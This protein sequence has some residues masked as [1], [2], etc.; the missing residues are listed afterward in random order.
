MPPRISGGSLAAVSATLIA[1]GLACSALFVWF[2]AEELALLFLIG[3]TLLVIG[4]AIAVARV[5]DAAWEV[6]G[7]WQWVAPDEWRLLQPEHDPPPTP[8]MERSARALDAARK[9]HLEVGVLHLLLGYVMSVLLAAN[10]LVPMA[11]EESVP[12]AVVVGLLL[13][14]WGEGGAIVVGSWLLHLAA[15]GVRQ[16]TGRGWVLLGLLYSVLGPLAH[17]LVS[18][19]S[20]IHLF[21]WGYG[22]WLSL[23]AVRPTWSVLSEAAMQL[24]DDA[25]A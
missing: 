15:R 11:Q 9:Y 17:G 19:A 14:L 12:A 25:H 16:Q 13:F 21:V 3:T 10:A 4:V 6:L 23:A 1:L 7:E 5:V 22:L 2:A 18:F 8:D 24:D 20:C